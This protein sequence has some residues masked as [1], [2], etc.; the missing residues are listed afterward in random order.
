M[1]VISGTLSFCCFLTVPFSPK[2]TVL[3]G[4]VFVGFL[5]SL[6]PDPQFGKSEF[7][8]TGLHMHPAFLDS[9]GKTLPKGAN[10]FKS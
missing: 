3:L 7:T 1:R 8:P 5:G 9:S 10:E 6:I 4:F 2:N